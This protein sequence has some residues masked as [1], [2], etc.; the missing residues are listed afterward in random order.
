MLDKVKQVATTAQA[1]TDV[2]TVAIL[3]VGANELDTSAAKEA[4]KALESAAEARDGKLEYTLVAVGELQDTAEGKVPYKYAEFTSDEGVI[5]KDAVFS[6]EKALR[7]VTDL[8]QLDAGINRTLSFM[9]VHDEDAPEYK[10]IKGLRAAG[11]PRP[12]EVDFM[13]N[14]GVDVS[15][16]QGARVL[17]GQ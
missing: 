5:H 8:L 3:L 4:V 14:S 12:T 2:E 17:F 6:R 11:Y 13:I 10:L 7:M 1:A 16:K 9:E 15:R